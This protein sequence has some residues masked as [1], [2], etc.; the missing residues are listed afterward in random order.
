MRWVRTDLKR[1]DCEK[2][3]ERM[4]LQRYGWDGLKLKA[5]LKRI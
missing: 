4:G 1:E 3:E 2:F 5:R